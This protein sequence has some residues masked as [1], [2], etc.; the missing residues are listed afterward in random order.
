MYCKIQIKHKRKYCSFLYTHIA[1]ISIS[2]CSS[3]LH[4]SGKCDCCV[5]RQ[6]TVDGPTAHNRHLSRIPDHN[7]TLLTSQGPQVAFS[8]V[9]DTILRLPPH[10]IYT[11]INTFMF[12]V[13]CAEVRYTPDY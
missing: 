3:G 6:I 7:V 10:R 4:I 9:F 13:V 2:L 12:L 5:A 8:E 1:F 11:N